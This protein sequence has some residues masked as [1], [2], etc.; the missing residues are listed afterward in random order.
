MKKKSMKNMPT[1]I[2]LTLQMKMRAARSSAWDCIG[3]KALSIQ[4]GSNLWEKPE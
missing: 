2:I 4:N 3:V 1:P